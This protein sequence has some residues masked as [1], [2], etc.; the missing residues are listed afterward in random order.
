MSASNCHPGSVG[1]GRRM[2]SLPRLASVDPSRADAPPDQLWLDR[3]N[4]RLQAGWVCNEVLAHDP[5]VTAH[6]AARHGV[7]IASLV[8]LL[9]GADIVSLHCPL[10]PDSRHLIDEQALRRM[11]PT[12][13]LINT[14][15]GSIVDEQTLTKALT[16]VWIAGAGLE[17]L[18]KEPLDEPSSLLRLD[19]FVITPHIVAYSDEYLTNCWW[20]SV[21]TVI[22]LVEGLWPA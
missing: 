8:E 13:V 14:A 17:V 10:T 11:K 20:L 7:R 22:A 12:A 5:F 16:E 19:R 6:E 2:G 1:A 21:E 18:E 4:C 3:A 15:R 9:S